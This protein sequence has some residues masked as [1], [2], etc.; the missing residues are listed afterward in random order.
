MKFIF[1]CG[2]LLCLV[3]FF[4]RDVSF[5]CLE[6]EGGVLRVMDSLFYSRSVFCCPLRVRY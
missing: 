2:L 3:K 1:H 4:R 6:G 5:C